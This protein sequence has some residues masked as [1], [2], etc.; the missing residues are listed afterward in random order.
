MA[1]LSQ[2]FVADELPQGNS[3]DFSPIPKGD[4]TAKIVKAD[5]MPTKAGDGEYIK[6]RLDILAPTHQGRVLFANLNIRNPSAKAEEI[7]RQQLGDIMRALGLAKVSDTDQLI[8][9][10]LSIK[11]DVKDSEQYGPSNEVK[12]YK[13]AG[14]TPAPIKSADMQQKAPQAEKKT[15]PWMK[16]K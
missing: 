7:G 6:L 2:T 3:G 15:P 9:G 13:S 14:G 12:A 4:Y 11:V 5:V 8:G 16:G 1:Q 10:E